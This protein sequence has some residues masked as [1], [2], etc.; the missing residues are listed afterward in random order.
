MVFGVMVGVTFELWGVM[1]SGGA[2]HSGAGD[3]P[4]VPGSKADQ[5]AVPPATKPPSTLEEHRA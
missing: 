1:V 4:G 5:T 2:N 3:W